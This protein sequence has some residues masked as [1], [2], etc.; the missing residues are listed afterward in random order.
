MSSTD[1]F[2]SLLLPSTFPQMCR[3]IPMTIYQ[4]KAKEVIIWILTTLMPWTHFRAPTRW[5]SPLQDLASRSL[6]HLKL[7]HRCH[8]QRKLKKTR[9]KSSRPSTKHCPTASPWRTPSPIFPTRSALQTVVWS[10]WPSLSCQIHLLPHL[11]RNC[12]ISRLKVPAR[13]KLRRVLWK[14]LRCLQK[15]LTL[16]IS[17]TLMP[18]TLFKLA[19]LKF[20]IPLLSTERQRARTK[21]L[22]KVKQAKATLRMMPTHQWRSRHNPL[23]PRWNLWLRWLQYQLIT[24]NAALLMN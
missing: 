23:N 4:Y 21:R 12:T 16:W 7:M 5:C 9:P 20:Q 11:M 14:K 6:P 19:A 3:L 15:A 24:N 8:R 10:K 1:A 13:R 18:S 22:K 2:N 17:T